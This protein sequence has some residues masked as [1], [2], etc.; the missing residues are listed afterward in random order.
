[1]KKTG[2]L[3]LLLAAITSCQSMKDLNKSRYN[4]VPSQYDAIKMKVKGMSGWMPGRNVTYGDYKALKI[5]RS[6]TKGSDAILLSKIHKNTEKYKTTSFTQQGLNGTKAKIDLVE[7]YSRKGI[8]FNINNH[9]EFDNTECHHIFSGTIKTDQQNRWDLFFNI[10]NPSSSKLIHQ[11][12][13]EIV[14]VRTRYGYDFLM[15]NKSVA[16]FATGVFV[17]NWVGLAEYV[18]IQPELSEEKKLVLASL[19]TAI[20]SRQEIDTSDPNDD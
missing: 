8:H 2:L 16:G 13:E 5:K 20:M 10:N 3:L 15:D 19:I 1:M 17:K 6:W 18:W 14:I 11:N 9:V 12:G 7:E 4:A